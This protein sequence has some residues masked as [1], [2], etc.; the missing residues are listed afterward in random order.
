MVLRAGVFW[1]GWLGGL[2]GISPTLLSQSLSNCG[3][4][5]SKRL[6][7]QY[8]LHFCHTNKCLSF[9]GP[10]FRSRSVRCSD[11]TIHIH[12]CAGA[13][14]GQVNLCGGSEPRGS[15]DSWIAVDQLCVSLWVP[16]RGHFQLLSIALGLEVAF[17]FISPEKSGIEWLVNRV[18]SWV[19]NPS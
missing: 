16:R 18:D 3:R 4:R 2:Y 6:Q 15:G 5:P 12:I 7:I 1:V 10:I 9:P 13:G 19:I 14:H 8:S 17:P 11:D